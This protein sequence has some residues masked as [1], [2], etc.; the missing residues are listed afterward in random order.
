MSRDL[1][2]EPGLKVALVCPPFDDK[3]DRSAYYLAPPLGLLYIAAYL[4]DAGHTV[5]VYDQVFD[6]KTGKLKATERLYLDSAESILESNPDVIAFST[7]C[8]TSPGAINIS[9][10]IKAIKPEAVIVLGG[11]DVSFL[12]ESYLNK[13]PF[14][15]YVLCGEAEI[16]TPKLLESIQGK[17]SPNT[18]AGLAYRDQ[19]TNSVHMVGGEERIANL[20][21]LLKP[22][23]D[24]V[25]PIKEYF[26]ASERPTMLIDSGR[27][28][29]YACEFCQTTLLNGQKVRYR[30]VTSIIAELKE[31]QN[32]YGQFEAYFIHDLFTARRSFVEELC[33]QLIKEQI[34]ITWQCRCRVD[35]MDE[36]LLN[37][38]SR[39]GCRML[40][41]GI[42]S[43]DEET[44]KAMN[45][46]R[47]TR[48]TL[49]TEELVRATVKAELF[50]SLSMVVG[51]PEETLEGLNS[52]MALAQRMLEIGSVNAFIQLM[53]P[54]PGTV[55]AK[56]TE[57]RF[58]YMGNSSPS[59]FSQG[60]E[61]LDGERLPEDE[62]LIK[63]HPD[64]F[65]S[66][67]IVKP[68]HGDIELCIDV[69]LAFCKL[70]EVYNYSFESLRKYLNLSHLELFSQYRR[71]VL[72][73]L[74]AKNMYGLKDADFW[75]FF[76]KFVHELRKTHQLPQHTSEL[77]RYEILINDIAVAS[78]VSGDRAQIGM[79]PFR[80]AEAAQV[81]TPKVD[82]PEIEAICGA[83]MLLYM[84]S[85]RL[86]LLSLPAHLSEALSILHE[87]NSKQDEDEDE[88]HFKKLSAI[89]TPLNPYGVFEY[90]HRD[91]Y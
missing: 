86:K 2:A 39:A 75:R 49:T 36:G 58:E 76:Q 14:I 44:L 53:S 32:R 91:P 56:R 38:M 64:I 10:H 52:T 57:H 28:C 48:Q 37:L 5:E 80:L 41:Y 73:K 7:Q 8:S 72:S 87:L 18:V 26:E 25:P 70:L 54:L 67:Q 55:L 59:A 21:D 24:L 89:L 22:R 4:M 3:R 27:G 69:S 13:F 71:F 46:L 61:F 60:I 50:P 79:Q 63:N 83:P 81:F 42:E 29:A 35:H 62:Q 12:A 68:D 23:Y 33:H 16:T 17:K 74:C 90:S 77:L 85:H 88:R 19:K 6:L 82:L 15:D 40:L 78:P 66:F 34:D 30:S 9:R 31:Y 47:R 43:G 65:M 1:I 45:K 11:H 84:T 51:I 20:D